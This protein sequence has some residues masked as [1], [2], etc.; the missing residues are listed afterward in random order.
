MSNSTS[1]LS[2]CVGGLFGSLVV[3]VG[4][5]GIGLF[6]AG[7]AGIGP[8]AAPAALQGV[9]GDTGSIVDRSIES[10]QMVV[11]TIAQAIDELSTTVVDTFRSR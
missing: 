11:T 8:L 5:I 9:G 3:A 6:F 2:G 1:C 10:L 7:Q 4:V